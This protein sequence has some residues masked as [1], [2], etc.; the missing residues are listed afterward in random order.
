MEAVR[1]HECLT[2][3]RFAPRQARVSDRLSLTGLLGKCCKNGS[4]SK[5]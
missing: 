4:V 2:E 5:V 3:A 1:W